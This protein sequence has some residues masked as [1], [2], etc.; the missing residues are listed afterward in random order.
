M[1]DD[2]LLLVKNKIK[3]AED[4]WQQ[5]NKKFKEWYEFLLLIDKLSA[6]GMESY[7]SNEPATFFQMAHYLLTKGE[8]THSIPIVAE[9]ATDLDTR[10][11]VHRGCQYM[12][13][14]IDRKRQLGG[15]Q[16]YSSELCFYLLVLGWYSTVF[17][18][19][20]ETGLLKAQIWSP[21]ETYPIYAN[22]QMTT[23]VHSYK[24]T[25]DEAMLK[26]ESNDWHYDPKGS[27]V[28]DVV[29]QD[30]FAKEGDIW[31]NMV[32]IDGQD[33]TG[34]VPRPEMAVYAA[35]VG[36]YPDKGMLT[37]SGR[38]WRGYVGKGIF[39]INASVAASFNK[40][41]SLVSQILRDTA[42]PITQEF[43]STPKA[44]PEQL[45]E[46]GALFNY[47]PGE[48]GLVR[49]PPASIPIEI[50]GSLFE[51]RREMQK[52]SFNDAVF[53]MM[54]GQ[55]GYALSMLASSSA[56]QI[57]Y[58]YM[59][60][61]H[62]VIGEADNFWLTNLKTSKRVFNIKGKL[63][64][65][66]SPTDIPEDTMV[67]VESD[68]ATPKDWLERG[69]IGGMVR[70]DIDKATL[71]TEIYK[72]SDPQGILRRK[73][74]D[75]VLD[76]PMTQQIELIAGYNAHADY[77]E[78]SGDRNQALLFRKAAKAME[79]QLGAPAPGQGSPQ[80]MTNILAQ[81]KAGSPQEVPTVPSRVAPPETRGFSPQQLRKT[82]GSGK[83]KVT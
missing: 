62:F 5:R 69:T 65:K 79:A 15:A 82:I 55:P 53:G 81:R 83:L 33:V 3:I 68:V 38:D 31:Q 48:A 23:C 73:T 6:R 36:G 12:W 19:D 52:G 22:N 43:S 16:S 80:E 39:E 10:A 76:N 7:V 18:F 56:N 64:E 51:L 44:T 11:R 25:K 77:L 17:A 45:R 4:F 67:T 78:R 32:I 14:T 41:K 46:R 34:L 35:P 29:L 47:A 26:A 13:H 42:Q 58:P 59:D 70:Q 74:L 21:A 9:S 50:Q 37:P 66:L 71:L 2:K 27:R 72:L 1:A 24:I 60:G 28:G 54:E 8:L 63:I 20:N 40:W 49:L 57:L 30:F 75:R 61:K